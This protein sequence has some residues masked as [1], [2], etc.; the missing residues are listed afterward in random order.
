LLRH[1]LLE[2]SVTV[3]SSVTSSEIHLGLF[4]TWLKRFGPMKDTLYKACALSVP[5]NGINVKW[6]QKLLDREK[7][8][9]LIQN[10]IVRFSSGILPQNMIVLRHSR[11][12]LYQFVITVQLPNRQKVQHFPV[13]SS[14]LGYSTNGSEVFRPTIIDCIQNDVIN[15]LFDSQTGDIHFPR[16]SLDEWEIIIL[17]FSI[18]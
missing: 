18:F 7:A 17:N 1:T 10:N 16:N 3:S 6:Y 2:E 13:Q 8:E 12:P 4:S 9:L 15:N 5:S 14:S 11:D